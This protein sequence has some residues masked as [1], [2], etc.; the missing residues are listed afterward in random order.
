MKATLFKE[1]GY[2]LSKLIADVDMG[3]IGLPDI[4]RPFVWTPTKVRDLF[5]SMYKGFPVGYLLF[6]ANS[7]ADGTRQIGTDPFKKV[8]RLL[9]VDGQQRLTSL[10]AVLKGQPVIRDDYSAQRMHIA[11]RPS[12]ARFEVADAAIRRNPE[13]IPD[14]SQLWVGDKSHHRFV[15]EFLHRLRAGREVSN[16]EEDHL[17]QAVDR[18]YDL[19]SYPFTALE[20][21]ASVDEEQVADVFVRI[22]S[23]GVPLNQADFI[24]TL[25]SVFWDEGRAELEQFSRASRLPGTG[26]PSPFN[27]FIQPDPD[28]LLRVAVALGFRRARLEH[29]YSILRGKDIDTGKFE[30]ARREEQFAILRTAQREMLNLDHWHEFLR[31]LIRAGF[32]SGGMISSRTGLLYAYA[33]FLIGQRDFGIERHVLR[34]L[35]ARWFFMTALTARYSSSPETAMEADLARLRPVKNAASFVATLDHLIADALT[36]DFWNI[37]LPNNLATSASQGPSLYAYYASLNLLDARVLFSNLKVSQLLDPAL[38]GKRSTLERHHIFPKS[39]LKQSGIESTSEI[40][41][42]GN[43]ALVEWPDNANISD[44]A[45]TDYFPQ[46]A[47]RVSPAELEEMQYWHALA[48]GWEHLPYEQFLEQRR[49]GIARVIRDGYAKLWAQHH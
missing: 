17:F 19:Q 13:Y 34:D 48:P 36:D 37:T 21:S 9:I 40:N 15:M 41:Q 25:M 43:F 11:F 1:V 35:I 38:K 24:L 28:Q 29:V 27:H 8:P 39:Y 32:R 44:S 5:G 45:P 31:S 42:I 16:E 22:N 23:K 6:W 4:Q 14:I 26:R 2:S 30:P 20:L 7:A 49:K 46:F 12:D 3:E 47:N 10:Y 33:M 18:L